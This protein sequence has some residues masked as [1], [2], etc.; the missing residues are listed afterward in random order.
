MTEEE[1][2]EAEKRQ[3][4]KPR[5]ENMYIMEEYR[6]FHLFALEG[7]ELNILL[8]NIYYQLTRIADHLTETK[9]PVV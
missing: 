9:S 1:R 7:S 3:Q 8:F 4:K 5:F 2:K 6:D